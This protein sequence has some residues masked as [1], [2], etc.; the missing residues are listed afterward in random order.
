[1]NNANA[2]GMRSFRL[3]EASFGVGRDRR[4]NFSFCLSSMGFPRTAN[5]A[6]IR[7]GDR[8]RSGNWL[9]FILA[10]AARSP[11]SASENIRF[12]RSSPR[13]SGT[14]DDDAADY[15]SVVS[16]RRAERGEDFGTVLGSKNAH[17]LFRLSTPLRLARPGMVLC[18]NADIPAFI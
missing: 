5:S 9:N 13:S 18:H 11:N 6:R 16:A 4:P 15:Y 3:S 7:Q 2:S 10:R 17:L 8:P 14:S 1:M 12:R